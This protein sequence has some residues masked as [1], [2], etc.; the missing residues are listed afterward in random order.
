[1]AAISVEGIGDLDN[2]KKRF[3]EGLELMSQITEEN[4]YTAFDKALQYAENK[5]KLRADAKTYYDLEKGVERYLA[6]YRK[7]VG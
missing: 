7:L 4:S 5:E 1:M 2:L 6:V 3:P